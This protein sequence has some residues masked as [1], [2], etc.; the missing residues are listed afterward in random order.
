MLFCSKY[1]IRMPSNTLTDIHRYTYIS[2]NNVNVTL[3][4]KDVVKAE[5][6]NVQWKLFKASI[7]EVPT[8]L[9]ICGWML[10]ST[11]YLSHI[12]HLPCF[13]MKNTIRKNLEIHARSYIQSNMYGKEIENTI[14]LSSYDLYNLK[15]ITKD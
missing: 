15:T 9:L 8:D 14:Y 2:C 4:P 3:E 13:R 10:I 12:G 1:N 7:T 5:N 11:H 6:T